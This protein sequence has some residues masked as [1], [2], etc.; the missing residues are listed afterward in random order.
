MKGLLLKAQINCTGRSGVVV[1]DRGHVSQATRDD[2]LLSLAGLPTFF[3]KKSGPLSVNR[4]VEM[5][6]QIL[7]ATVPNHSSK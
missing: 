4:V 3:Q 5:P 1:V 6:R 2:T 7:Y